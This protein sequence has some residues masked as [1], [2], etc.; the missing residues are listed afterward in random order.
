MSFKFRPFDNSD[1]T[2]HCLS[3]HASNQKLGITLIIIKDLSS[4]GFNQSDTEYFETLAPYLKRLLDLGV[5]LNISRQ[6][7]DYLISLIDLI[8]EAKG[9]ARSDGQILHVNKN[10]LALFGIND[11]QELEFDAF[12]LDAIARAATRP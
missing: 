7:T 8:G 9:L 5:I 3:C 11:Y 2:K 4:T 10:A 12:W 6:D 1:K